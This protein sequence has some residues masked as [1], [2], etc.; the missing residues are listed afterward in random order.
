[1]CK[2]NDIGPDGV[3][4]LARLIEK[5]ASLKELY[6]YRILFEAFYALWPLGSKENNIGDDGAKCLAKALKTNISLNEI[7]LED[8]LFDIFI[9][10]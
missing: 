3:T 6:L 5:T 4:E 1:M 7:S 8:N 9:S 10:S 2:A